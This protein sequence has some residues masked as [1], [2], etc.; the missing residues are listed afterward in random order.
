MLG[1]LRFLPLAVGVAVQER[2]QD[3]LECVVFDVLVLHQVMREGLNVVEEVLNRDE[4]L[5]GDTGVFIVELLADL[6]NVFLELVHF[7]ASDARQIR[8]EEVLS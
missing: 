4:L 5:H 7:F 2:C 3:L 1:H 8:L 6:V